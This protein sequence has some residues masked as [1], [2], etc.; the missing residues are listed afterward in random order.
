MNKKIPSRKRAPKKAQP[1]NRHKRKRH[2]F[3][4]AWVRSP[5][6]MGALLPSS[7]RL[8]KAMVAEI[9]TDKSG[10]IIELGAGTGVM[11]HALLEAGIPPERLLVIERDPKL[12]ATLV[13]QF[14]D[15]TVL[16]ED[17]VNLQ[18]LLTT[19]KITKVCAILSSIPFL[20]IPKPVGKAIQE[21]MARVIDKDGLVVQFTYGIKSP[22]SKKQLESCGMYAKRTKMVMTNVPPAHV[23][24]FRKI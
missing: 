20:T 12:H 16:C 14:P 22:I 4:A 24:V 19:H 1:N 21:Q 3:I 2:H 5:M 10:A 18:E 13:T 9:D 7:R 15:L 17:A 6:G 8:A 11:T 23:W